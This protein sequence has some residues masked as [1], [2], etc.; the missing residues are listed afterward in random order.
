MVC[1]FY[2]P[3][4]TLWPRVCC[5]L[6]G[7]LEDIERTVEAL[8]GMLRAQ[9]SSRQIMTLQ[10]FQN[11]IT[12]MFALGGSTNA[13]LHLLALAR[14]AEVPTFRSLLAITASSQER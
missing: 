9:T 5:A 14:E 2:R 12:V 8:F 11:A 3:E 4:V 1:P 7:K 10:A 6:T 13:V